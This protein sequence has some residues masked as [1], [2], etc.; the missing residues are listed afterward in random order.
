MLSNLTKHSSKLWRYAGVSFI[1]V[2]LTQALLFVLYV[3][4][5]F[6]GLSANAL[7]VTLAAI[8]GYWLNRSWVW[9]KTDAHSLTREVL[10]FWILNLLGLVL[11]TLAVWLV[12][13]QTE[14]VWA[15]MLVNV[16]VFGTIWLLKFSVINRWL[17]AEA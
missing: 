13:N 15:L 4:A 11:S 17:F 9:Q 12:E 6:P 10:P 7:A 3:V 1:T 16:A 2:P 14:D 8:P 5:G